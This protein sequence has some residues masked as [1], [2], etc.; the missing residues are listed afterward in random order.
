MNKKKFLKE[1]K[2]VREE[3]VE[4]AG[5]YSIDKNLELRTKID[6][7]LIMYDQACKQLLTDSKQEISA[8]DFIKE[9]KEKVFIPTVNT[10]GG[11]LIDGKEL[12]NML[13][14][15]A[16]TKLFHHSDISKIVEEFFKW[17]DGMLLSED[18]LLEIRTFAKEYINDL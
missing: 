12:E 5:Q 15:Y 6:T 4:I 18:M 3:L 14:E 10:D 9:Y 16:K 11:L 17:R 2:K 13:E 8:K 7:L 1:A